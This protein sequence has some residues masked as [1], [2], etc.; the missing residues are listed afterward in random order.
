M[1]MQLKGQKWFFL[2]LAL[3]SIGAVVVLYYQQTPVLERFEAHT[4]DLRFKA[5]RGAVAPHPDIAIIA[6]NDRSIAEFGRFPWSRKH[7]V[8]LLDKVSA[9]GAK[10]LLMDAFFPE[11]EDEIT[12]QAFADALARAGNVVLAVAFEFNR[13]GTIKGKT[14]SLPLLADAAGAEGHINFHPDEDGV[15][16]RSVL[17]IEDQGRP[18]PSLALRGAMIALGAKD[19]HQGSF[20]VTVGE[21][22]IPTDFFGT[23]LINYTGPPG[24]YPIYSFADVAQG[25][26]SPDKLRGKILFMG[27]TAL[28]IY[29]MRVTPFHSNTPGVEINATIADNIISGSFVRRSGIEALIDL[30]FIVFLGVVVFYMTVRLP[31]KVTLPAFLA[32]IFV[33]LWFAYLMFENGRWLSM[34]YPLVSLLLTY[35]VSTAFHFI[36]LDRRSRE[37]RSVFSSY[38]SRNVVDQL[39]VDP[40]SARIGGDLRD[41]TILFLDVKGFTAISEDLA[42]A[43]VVATLNEYLAILTRIIME[44]DGTVDKFLGDGIM[45]YWGAPLAQEGHVEAAVSCTLEMMAVSDRMAAKKRKSSRPPLSFRVGINSGEVIAGNIGLKGK[46]MEY[47]LV[48]DNVNLSARLEGTA[49]FYG[50]DVLVGESTYQATSGKFLYRELDCIR[51]V[52]KKNAVTVYELITQ[53]KGLDPAQSAVSEKVDRFAVGLNLYRERNWLEASEVFGGL[54]EDYPQDK[55]SAIYYQRCQD[56]LR[57]PPPE[58]WDFIFERKEK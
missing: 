50:V 31:P 8:G 28:G 14:G 40:Q 47:T 42:P 55:P 26:V 11:P 39:V 24:T 16:R 23:M 32:I 35:T 25:R 38:V 5:M 1:T 2:L 53:K 33:Y 46:K 17:L 3:L 15:N 36:I 22:Q 37:I 43:E 58:D 30:F 21:R 9:A 13:D 7:Y 56:F 57:E 54:Q 4:Y 6:I 18:Q 44:H 29:D 34:V 10:A 51:V 19:I 52:G 45:A 41:V 27:M 20:E 48:G 49:K 12:D